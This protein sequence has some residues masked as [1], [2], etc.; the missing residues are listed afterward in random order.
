MDKR[1]LFA[2][3]LLGSV[4]ALSLA[5]FHSQN[6]VSPPAQIVKAQG[7]PSQCMNMTSSETECP[8]CGGFAD[9]Y[10]QSS[11][12]GTTGIISENTVCEDVPDPPGS[13]TY[14][15]NQVGRFN[16]YCCD[17]DNDGYFRTSCG[18]TDCNDTPGSGYDI[19]PGRQESCDGID[20]NCVNGIDEGYDKDN[21]GYK[22]CTGDCDDT[23]GS[24]ASINPGASEV[25]DGNDNNC[26]GQV[27]VGNDLDGDLVTVAQGDCEDCD[28]SIYP[29]AP[30]EGCLW[31]R[32]SDCD[33]ITDDMEC[34]HSPIVIDILGNG[35]A[36]TNLADGVDFDLNS[37]GL[38]EQISWTSAGSDDSW[39]ALDRNGNGQIDNGEELF[40]N[41]TP[42]PDPPLGVMRNGFLALAEYDKPGNG[43]NND[44]QID[45]RDSIF[46]GLKLWR[47][48]NHNGVSEMF[49]MQALSSSAIRVLELRYRESR[50]TDEHGNQFRYRAKVRDLHGAQVGRWAWDVFLLRDSSNAVAVPVVFQYGGS[51]RLG[52]SSCGV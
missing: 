52:R 18:G 42:Q 28:S 23:P 34:V 46:T 8:G 24:G 36:L 31:N 17:Q 39:L 26:D 13:C 32:D 33:G 30:P 45:L 37:N 16:G 11:G 44:R 43:G 12:D 9:I 50:R 10:F 2:L 15:N 20:N 7:L 29:G 1:L 4:V 6:R 41:Y 49:E 47:D 25:C 21:D 22:T 40:G 3:L 19:N 14:F 27:D 38:S 35:F 51:F 48:A 5:A